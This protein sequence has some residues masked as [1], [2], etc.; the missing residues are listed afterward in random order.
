MTTLHICGYRLA[1]KH[2]ALRRCA[3]VSASGI[4]AKCTEM[5]LAPI[6]AQAGERPAL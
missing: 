6:N 4:H 2:Q 1:T 3:N 5:K